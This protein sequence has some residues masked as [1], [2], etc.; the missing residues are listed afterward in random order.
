MAIINDNTKTKIKIEAKNIVKKVI[1]ILLIVS[2]ITIFLVGAVYVITIDDGTNK[3]GDWGSTGYGVSQY[4]NNVQV[5]DNGT[6]SSNMETKELWDKMLKNGGRVDKYLDTPEELARLMK[7]EIVT[8]YPDV[9]KNP[10]EP[11]NWE[12]IV[13]NSDTLQGIIKFK[14]SDENNNKT[15][16]RYAKP[17]EFQSYI[18]EYNRTGSEKAKKE[19]LTHFTLQQT[20]NYSGGV[21]TGVEAGNNTFISKTNCPNAYQIYEELKKI[22]FSDA[23]A[24]AVLGNLFQESGGAGTSDINPNDGDSSCYGIAQWTPPNELYSYA[25]QHGL[26]PSSISTQVEFLKYTLDSGHWWTGSTSENALKQY[27]Y[28]DKSY[29]VQEFY[30]CTDLKK[31]TAMFLGYYEECIR[32]NTSYTINGKYMNL[33]ERAEYE[34]NNRYTCA[35]AAYAAF[36]GNSPSDTATNKTQNNSNSSE[37]KSNCVALVASWNQKDK[38]IKTNDPNV[39]STYG[40]GN[41]ETVVS[42]EYSMTTTTVNYQEMVKPYSVPFDL[43]WEFLV[44]GE[45]KSFVFDFADL[46][47]NSDIQVTIYDN[48]TVNTD[49]ENWK[50]SKRT[51]AEV[52]VTDKATYDSG[53][54]TYFARSFLVDHVDEP[55][56]DDINYNTIKTIVTKTNT[57]NA[58]L[59]KANVWT[60]NYENDYTYQ[61]PTQSNGLS[62]SISK[63]DQNYSDSPTRV[64][65]GDNVSYNGSCDEIQN[66]K[67]IAID[68]VLDEY[69]KDTSNINATG[70]V[71]TSGDVN[72]VE[73]YTSVKYYERYVNI[74][75]NTS[76]TVSTQNYLQGV[77][78]TKMKTDSDVTEANFVKIFKNRE[79]RKTYKN[80]TSVA[81]WLFELIE[82]NESTADFSD[83]IRYL[84]YMATGNDYGVTEFDFTEFEQSSFSNITNLSNTNI[85]LEYLKSWENNALWK[86]EKGTI[87]Y[88]NYVAKFI[89][90]DKKQ[91]VCYTDGG[92]RLNFGYGMCHYYSGHY[93]HVELY[94]NLG[95][96][97]T[98][99]GLGSTIDVGIV[100]S[101][102]LQYIDNDRATTKNKLTLAGLNLK[103]TQI[104]ALTAISYQWGNH[105]IDD[106]ISAYK[107]YGDTEALRQNFANGNDP[108]DKP[109]LNGDGSTGS[110][111]EVKRG[112][113]NWKLFHEGIYTT[114]DGEILDPNSYTG[115]GN[116][117]IVQ[118]AITVHNYVRVNG[119]T[120]AQLGISLPNYSGRTIDCSS[121]VTWVLINSGV[122]GFSNGM[123]QWT[124]SSFYSNA[125]GWQQVSV[126]QAQPGDILVYD[127]HVEIVAAQGSDSFI[128]YNCGGNSSIRSAGSGNLAE[129]SV[130]GH[131]KSQI[132]KILRV[133]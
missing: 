72:V 83:L 37:K 61:S 38:K 22:G 24:C 15:T 14:R 2:I 106:F 124:S 11:I 77:A 127:G 90:K 64:D 102:K 5:N 9:R 97:I 89:T 71:P 40:I 28:L 79:H 65:R 3:K 34:M 29:T 125:Y 75:D 92:N 118:S 51:K 86:Y 73:N 54:K 68:R 70:K 95:V 42:S 103:D 4:V 45:E 66:L 115:G 131:K 82:T 113:A 78:K 60:V 46:I 26:N 27:G 18:D 47:Y 16:M 44:I 10:D 53:T 88:S 87:S 62:Q 12:E 25:N 109:F 99:F 114:P 128:V 39:Q 23:S 8:Q 94:S 84:L 57:I 32:A 111:Y 1:I 17:E 110:S 105:I 59:T 81:S 119:Y 35:T 55:Y 20:V 126:D 96:D 74:T 63:A 7:A 91:Y 48:V 130:S 6:L 123:G 69:S 108:S 36:A 31:A 33:Q 52:N 58:V 112:N 121:Y 41:E 122:R 43:L 107:K 100:D 85:L 129:A 117:T 30:S 76:N 116:T 132:L 133:P 98:K 67:Q 13:K 104:D 80:V 19:A 49:V 50:Y 120:Y 56:G 21:T 93:N 101:A